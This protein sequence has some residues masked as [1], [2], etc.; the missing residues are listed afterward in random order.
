LFL[1]DQESSHAQP[2]PNFFFRSCSQGSLL[3]AGFR[4]APYL[5]GDEIMQKV[6]EPTEPMRKLTLIK[7]VAVTSTGETVTRQ[8]I[9][10]AQ[11]DA[12]GNFLYLLRFTAPED[13]KGTA[14]ARPGKRWRRQRP[15]P[16]SA[17]P[18]QG[19]PN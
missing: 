19:D 3:S 6:K 2:I 4:N 14:F 10:A 12:K 5:T 11:K 18:R 7:M 15:I 9:S 8:F 16:L 1:I 17:R 13:Q